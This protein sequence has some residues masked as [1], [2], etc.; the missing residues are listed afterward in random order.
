MDRKPSE[1]APKLMEMIKKAMDDGEITT[2]EYN[3]ILA[4]ADEDGHHDPQEQKLLAQ[5]QELLTN[6]VI[7]RV[8]G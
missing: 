2:T 4:I 3:K 8:P 7:K 5:L 1:S 6:K